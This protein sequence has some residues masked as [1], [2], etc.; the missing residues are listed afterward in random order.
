M[1]YLPDPSNEGLVYHTNHAIANDDVKPWY[2]AFQKKVK[3]GEA[4]N[5]NSVIRLASLKNSLNIPVTKITDIEL[6]KAFRAKDD[7]KNPVCRT[8][9]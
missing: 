1:H 8:F 3:A 7:P 6:M 5:D 2:Q 9:K 4:N